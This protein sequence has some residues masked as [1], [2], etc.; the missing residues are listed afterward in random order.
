MNSSI[1]FTLALALM[2][3]GTAFAQH[4]A[5]KTTTSPN[6]GM[7]REYALS[8][9]LSERAMMDDPTILWQTYE[10]GAMPDDVFYID[11]TGD[12]LVYFGLN[13]KRVTLFDANGNIR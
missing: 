7:S 1:F 2:L 10:N 13:D 12:Y 3:S 5:V 11:A 6:T 8:N 9:M 4:H